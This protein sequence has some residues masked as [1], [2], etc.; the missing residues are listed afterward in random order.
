MFFNS[1]IQLVLNRKDL[2]YDSIQYILTFL[3]PELNDISIRYAINLWFTNESEAIKKYGHITEWN[4][5]KVTDMYTLFE[6]RYDFNINIS[7][8]CTSNVINMSYMFNNAKNF[9]QLLTFDTSNVIYMV[10]MFCNA[11]N[12]NKPLYFNTSKVTNMEAMFECATSFD[13][14]LLLNTSKV[15]NMH[16]MFSNES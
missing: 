16:C 12:F 9:D 10:G 4:T 7:K 13:Q 2:N 6:N 14:P 8:W 15:T 5:S 1:F 3:P 11:K